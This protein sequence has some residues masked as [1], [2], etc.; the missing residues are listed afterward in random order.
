MNADEMIT[1]LKETLVPGEVAELSCDSL[2]DAK[3]WY[4]R[5]RRSIDKLSQD[6]LTVS[7]SGLCVYVKH[8]SS[9]PVLEIKKL[10]E[11]S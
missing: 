1:K 8:I 4:M 2:T 11:A 10:S 3:T 9:P 7:R 6:K 5:F